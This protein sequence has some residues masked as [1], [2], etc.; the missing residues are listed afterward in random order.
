ME[1]LRP[2]LVHHGEM[3]FCRTEKKKEDDGGSVNRE[4]IHKEV[5]VY[6]IDVISDTVLVS[7]LCMRKNIDSRKMKKEMCFKYCE[8]GKKIN[9]ISVRFYLQKEV[10]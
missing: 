3:C 4:I 9:R 6:Y 8:A 5:C 2:Y 7:L 1:L 10:R